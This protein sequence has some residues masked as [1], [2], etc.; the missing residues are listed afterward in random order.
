M[1][2]QFTMETDCNSTTHT[3]QQFYLGDGDDELNLE[4]G[5]TYLTLMIPMPEGY[6]IATD[7]DRKGPKPKGTRH[8]SSSCASLINSSL[9]DAWVADMVYIVPDTP[10][11]VKVIVAGREKMIDYADA[12]RLGLV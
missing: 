11:Q 8:F 2:K 5:I 9:E 6:R 7:E 3:Y 12:E 10:E 1:M 4:P